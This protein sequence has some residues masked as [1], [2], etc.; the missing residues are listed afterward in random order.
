MLDYDDTDQAIRKNVDIDDKIKCS[1]FFIGPVWET[2]PNNIDNKINLILENEDKKTIF[3]NESGFY[4]LILTSKKSEAKLFKK[5]VTSEVLPS[6]RKTG[7]YNIINN[8]VE[9]KLD[10][11]INKD[12]KTKNS[13]EFLVL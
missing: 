4:S 1:D 5:W 7:S 3:I 8:Y 10:K 11:Y 6:I 12:C 9:E 13:K 2:G